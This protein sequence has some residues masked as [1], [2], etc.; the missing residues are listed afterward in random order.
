MSTKN[1]PSSSVDRF[2]NRDKNNI[3]A[4][5]PDSDLGNKIKSKEML[6]KSEMKYVQ[7]SENEK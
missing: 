1:V 3:C 6:T 5:S 2:V 7:Y 4:L